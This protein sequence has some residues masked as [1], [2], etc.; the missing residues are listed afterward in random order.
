MSPRPSRPVALGRGIAAA[1]LAT[2]ALAGCGAVEV[3]PGPHAADPACA[4]M[5]QGAPETM[6]GLP[7]HE[8]T[9]Q[10]TVAW[11]SGDQAVVLRCG[12]TPPGPTS[13]ACT[14]LEDSRGIAVDWIV[15]EENGIVTM[16]TF[17]RTPAV[18]ITVP[19]AVA[20]DQPSAAALEVAGLVAPLT[21]TDR[22][23]GPGDTA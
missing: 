9:S 15:R 6:L 7:R 18:D 13:D 8:T 3:P 21:Q 19:R 12:V 1:L 5:I 14:R 17:G 2:G 23:I 22:C 16:T 10:G 4:A 11:G 20:P